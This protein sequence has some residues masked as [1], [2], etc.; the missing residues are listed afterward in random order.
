MP[1]KQHKPDP[2]GVLPMGQTP[3]MGT[4]QLPPAVAPRLHE[5]NS[6]FES[7]QRLPPVIVEL[8][9]AIKRLT[10]TFAVLSQLVPNRHDENATPV[11]AAQ[12]IVVPVAPV[13]FSV[14]RSFEPT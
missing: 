7:R 11:A 5:K 6:A 3:R 9:D 1:E 10:D 13:R 12:G 14:F 4:V 2:F 8:A